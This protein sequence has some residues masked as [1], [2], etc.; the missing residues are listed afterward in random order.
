MTQRCEKTKPQTNALP[1]PY[2]PTPSERRLIETHRAK[3]NAKPPAPRMKVVE[4]DGVV[5]LSP[6][7]PEPS[8][9]RDCLL[10]ALGSRDTDFLEGLLKQLGNVSSQGRSID[11]EGLNFM[12]AIVKGIEPRDQVEA[13]LAA[14]MAAVHNATMTFRA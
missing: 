3:A 11:E 2:E 9:A 5:V 6:D 14:Q 12:L 10:E 13:M 1:K 8:I 4:K 7:H